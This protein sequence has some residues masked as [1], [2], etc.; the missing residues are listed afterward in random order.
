MWLCKCSQIFCLKNHLI[1]QHV[2]FTIFVEVTVVCYILINPQTFNFQ[3]GY[4]YIDPC[5][6]QDCSVCRCFP[7]KG[8]RVSDD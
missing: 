1:G 3:G 4:A 2:Q 8:S 7:E 6:G 5:G